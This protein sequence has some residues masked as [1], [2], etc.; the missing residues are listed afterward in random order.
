M[1][2]D[3]FAYTHEKISMGLYWMA[4]DQMWFQLL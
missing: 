4:F 2:I 1:P 3:P